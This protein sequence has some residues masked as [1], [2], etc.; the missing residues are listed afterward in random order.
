MVPYQA[1]H[2]TL[3]R[4]FSAPGGARTGAVAN[5]TPPIWMLR[6]NSI[7]AR[8]AG[9][10]YGHL[11]W[12]CRSYRMPPAVGPDCSVLRE[13]MRGSAGGL[14]CLGV[15]ISSLSRSRPWAGSLRIFSTC[16]GGSITPARPDESTRTVRASPSWGDRASRRARSTNTV[17]PAAVGTPPMVMS[18]MPS[19]SCGAR[20]PDLAWPEQCSGA[21][22]SLSDLLRDMPARAPC[23]GLPEGAGPA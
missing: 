10:G 18:A 16:R 22:S 9:L 20:L 3:Q 15:R 13:I 23:A 11:P 14:A 2:Q 1:W 4:H 8:M 21:G 12:G 5:T 6:K 7:A 17:T 19:A